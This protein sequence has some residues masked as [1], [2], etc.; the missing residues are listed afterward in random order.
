[1]VGAGKTGTGT[2]T[3]APARTRA[4][5][6]GVDTAHPPFE[7]TRRT[8]ARTR[9]RARAR[10]P[11]RTHVFTR[12]PKRTHAPIAVAVLRVVGALLVSALRAVRRPIVHGVGAFRVLSAYAYKQW[13]RDNQC[14]RVFRRPF[15][16]SASFCGRGTSRAPFGV[17]GF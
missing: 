17:K 4:P 6:V 11:P 7:W 1:M 5:T 15:L 13:P 12:A 16:Q 9:A 8:H 14:L 10:A 2:D 3:R